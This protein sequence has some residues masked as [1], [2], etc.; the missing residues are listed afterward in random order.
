M[1]GQGRW[2]GGR[3]E[4]IWGGGAAGGGDADGQSHDLPRCGRVSEW[5]AQVH[6]WAGA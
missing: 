2:A 3:G 6:E 4:C 1:E 5:W